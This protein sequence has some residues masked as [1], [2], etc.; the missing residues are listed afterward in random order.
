MHH[1]LTASTR[2]HRNRALTTAPRQL[3]DVMEVSATKGEWTV[4]AFEEASL[5]LA[6]SNWH[7]SRSQRREEVPSGTVSICRFNE[8]RHFEMR[9]A[10]QF[11][12]FLL[13]NEALEQV[14]EQNRQT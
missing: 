2:S 6:I 4:A 3:V 14:W 10:A 12:V 5:A 1:E 7:D 8:D 13:R 9:K 11:A